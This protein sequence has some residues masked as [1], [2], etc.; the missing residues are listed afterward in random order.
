M[1]HGDWLRRDRTSEG[2]WD[3]GDSSD[4]FRGDLDGDEPRNRAGDVP[5]RL[6][7]GCRLVSRYAGTVVPIGRWSLGA[8]GPGQIGS[9]EP[10]EQGTE[11]PGD[12]GGRGCGFIGARPSSDRRTSVPMEQG[13][14]VPGDR[15][16]SA[17]R[18]RLNEGPWSVR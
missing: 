17:A 4:R 16:T 18:V 12:R 9:S 13:T 14:E 3:L 7:A 10:M 8:M 2:P 6:D 11:V 5:S 15:G 1:K